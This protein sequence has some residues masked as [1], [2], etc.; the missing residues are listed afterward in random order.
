MIFSDRF[1]LMSSSQCCIALHVQGLFHIARCKSGIVPALHAE[2]LEDYKE[3][4]TDLA[5]R[6]V[7]L[8]LRLVAY[9][10]AVAEHRRRI[11]R[12]YLAGQRMVLGVV[13]EAGGLA[14]EDGVALVVAVAQPVQVRSRYVT[15]VSSQSEGL[16]D[17][18]VEIG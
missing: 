6:V 18:V 3:L 12:R 1:P 17:L 13:S 10:A 2:A 15:K 14:V 7:D 4:M 16:L 8:D 9:F 5:S 11:C